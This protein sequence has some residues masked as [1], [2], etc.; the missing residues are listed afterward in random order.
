MPQLSSVRS[1]FA[2]TG[3]ALA[4]LT[5]L[6]AAQ[7]QSSVTLSGLID[8]SAGQF[9]APGGLKTKAVQ[10]GNMTTSFFGVKGTE[11]LG[12]GYAAR[13]TMESFLRADSGAFGRF[14]GDA[15][16]ARSAWVGLSS[17]FGSVNLGRNTTSLFVST[18]LFNAFGDSF[19]F[20][21]SIRHYFASGTA[22]GDTGWNHSISYTTPNMG[23]LTGQLQVAGSNGDGGRNVGG[24]LVYFSGPLGATAAY[25]KVEKGATVADTTTGQLGVSY[26]FKV[27][28]VFGQLG[29]VDN[30]TTGRSYKLGEAGVSVPV[31]AGKALLQFGQL[32]PDVGN[33]RTTISTGYDYNLSKRTDVYAVFMNDKI[34]VT[35]TGKTYAVGVRHRF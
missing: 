22:T 8:M 25:Q 19:G 1:V 18:L 7:A 17:P 35:G 27:V 33:K 13:F 21:P 9:Q 11:D 23:G 20:S 16:W 30:D 26:D 10:S 24:N 3:L 14:T 34:A 2:R 12:G 4:A 15:F 31:G 28:K 32:K 6:G 5:A 29:K